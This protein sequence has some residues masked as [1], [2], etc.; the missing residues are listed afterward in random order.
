MS[1]HFGN[2]LLEQ[3]KLLSGEAVIVREDQLVLE[4]KGPDAKA[5][6]HSLTSQN[7]LNLKAGDSTES[8]LLSP[9]GHIEQQLKVVAVEDGLFLIVN[10]DK[11]GDLEAWLRKM[12]FRS[13]VEILVRDDLVIA[14]SFKDLALGDLVWVDPWS[15]GS[16]G[17][18]R[19]SKDVADFSYREYLVPKAQELPFEKA[20]MLAFDALR[21]S[22]GRPE[23]TDIDE[24]TLPHEFDWMNSA[25]HL[26]KGCYRGQESVAK[27]HNLGH[28]PRR[29]AILHLA[30]GDSLAQKG[31]K[32]FYLDKEVGKVL[33]GGLH[34]EAGSIA[35]ALLNRNTPYLD[36]QIEINGSMVACTQQVL[37]PADAGKAANL[38]RPAAFK[39]SGKK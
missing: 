22:A 38:P 19:Y 18:I 2:P 6:L 16:K 29:I 30:D 17:G 4:I 27:I 20:G 35:L 36:L 25:V 9:Q 23:I 37:V 24:R 14:G 7:I 39:L 15:T 21:I 8:L 26:S 31:D 3:R 10:R 1:S 34:Y 11:A 32:V 13:K 12:I 33:L 5:F 28:P